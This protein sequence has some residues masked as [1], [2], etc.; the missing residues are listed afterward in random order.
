MFRELRG[1]DEGLKIIG[2][3]SKFQ[4]KLFNFNKRQD[5]QKM[6][7]ETYCPKAYGENNWTKKYKEWGERPEIITIYGET[8]KEF[9]EIEKLNFDLGIITRLPE[10]Y[11]FLKI[12]IS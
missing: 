9:P 8:C 12:K 5:I 2:N 3:R 11:N 6:I 7:E 4:K 1:N 10:F